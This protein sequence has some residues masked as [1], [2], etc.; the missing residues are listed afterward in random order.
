MAE[1]LTL[2]LG[3]VKMKK[4]LFSV[5]IIFSLVF[6]QA[7]AADLYIVKF[8]SYTWN[9]CSFSKDR[10][11]TC[12]AI[13]CPSGGCIVPAEVNV[14]KDE[15]CVKEIL[16]RRGIDHLAGVYMLIIESRIEGTK[17]KKMKVVKSYDLRADRE[18][19]NLTLRYE[20][21]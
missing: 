11:G 14:C 3:E 21:K 9:P 19:E 4:L 13:A 20:G 12:L 17:I 6:S 2:C 16:K 18:E 8:E 5:L 10:Y 7:Y 1:E 15:E